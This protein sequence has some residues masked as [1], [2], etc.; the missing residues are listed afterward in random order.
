[1]EAAS[2]ALTS[3][4]LRREQTVDGHPA[5]KEDSEDEWEDL[6]YYAD[7]MTLGGFTILNGPV[8]P[9]PPGP[10]IRNYL[11]R[12]VDPEPPKTSE[13]VKS[14]LTHFMHK[15][16][17]RW[18]LNIESSF[19]K[20]K[21]IFLLSKCY[22]C[23]L[24]KE[25]GGQAAVQQ[26]LS[27]F[28]QDF[29]SR[30]WITYREGFHRISG[31]LLTSD[32]GWG[33]MVRAAQMI[34]AQAMV[35]HFLGR[36]WNMFGEQSDFSRIMH[37]EIIRWFG[38]QPVQTSPFSL[39]RLVAI[40]KSIDRKPG[41]W[42]GPACVAGLLAKASQIA[43]DFV[44]VLNEVCVYVG[45]DGAIYKQ[46]VIDLAT[47]VTT[48]QSPLS[49]LQSSNPEWKAVVILIPLAL[50]FDDSICPTVIPCLKALFAL[51]NFLGIIGG[52]PRHAL[53]LIGFQGDN[54]IY[55]D[56]HFMQETVDISKR[57]FPVLTYHSVFPRKVAF[58]KLE[59]SCALGFYCRTREDFQNFQAKVNPLLYPADGEHKH[60][61]FQVYEG[62]RME[63]YAARTTEKDF[64]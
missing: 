10:P 41:D 58:T 26:T 44:P 60:P 14:R 61:I 31:S 53:Y 4:D 64:S 8:S 59:S 24:A 56:P 1:M 11:R 28:K 62:S 32:S 52:T 23:R 35:V 51:D 12:D 9:P 49:T 15:V 21:A 6:T 63:Q 37:K 45:Y 50:G 16:Q 13:K 7:G 55:L 29:T 20:K 34:L 3:S 33:C 5:D 46:D 43:S 36:D 22:D 57:E 40:A 48:D 47:G 19:S 2:A 42:Y 27:E 54:A 25:E 39:H 17:Y 38:D 18:R 30:I